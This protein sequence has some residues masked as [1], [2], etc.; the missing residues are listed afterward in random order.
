MVAG[1][2]QHGHVDGDEAIGRDGGADVVDPPAE[3]SGD[4]PKR[5]II[6]PVRLVEA[7]HEFLEGAEGDRGQV[8]GEYPL[9]GKFL[10]DDLIDRWIEMIA[11]CLQNPAL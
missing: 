1:R 5:C 8:F 7:D 3:I 9:M 2:S 11:A 10:I 6:A 4:G